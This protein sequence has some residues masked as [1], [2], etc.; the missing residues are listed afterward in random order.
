MLDH[1]VFSQYIDDTQAV[2]PL[3]TAPSVEALYRSIFPGIN[4]AVEYIRVYSAICWMVRQIDLAARKARDP[5]IAALSAAGLEKIQLLLTWYN[6][7]QEVGGLAGADRTWPQDN[8]R[9]TLNFESIPGTQTAKRLAVDPDYEVRDGGAHFLTAPQY[10]PSLV[11][12]MRFLEEIPVLPGT[13]RL[14][15]AG[16]ELAN[17]YEE[18]IEHHERRDWLASVTQVT[19]RRDEMLLLGDMLDLRE[20]SKG[21]MAAFV[22]Q[23]YPDEGDV[24]AGAQWENRWAGLTLALRAMEAEQPASMD[25]GWHGVPLDTV[26]FAMARGISLAGTPLNLD[27]I[28]EVQGWWANLQLRQYLRLAMETLGRCVQYWIHDAVVNEQPRDISDCAQRLGE[29]VEIILREDNR[30]SSVGMLADELLA[31]QGAHGSFFE[32][33]HHVKELRLEDMLGRLQAVCNFR[34][35]AEEEKLAL[36]EVY[37]ALVYCAVEAENLTVNPYVRQEFDNDRIPLTALREVLKQYRS[38]APSAFL[39][40]MVRYYVI[41]LHFSVVQD[42][43]YDGRNRF[44]FILGDNGLERVASKGDVGAVGLMQDRLYHA[45]LLLAQCGLVEHFDDDTW[46]LTKAGRRRLRGTER[47]AQAA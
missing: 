39:A 21:E 36:R 25:A 9:V 44:F 4:N 16:E 31:L 1:P 29:R 15:P 37:I 22:S 45:M 26:R 42:R 3:G 35:N 23:F 17:A 43:T 24:V 30:D 11:R 10:R 40:H 14:T 13:Y 27:E 8:R 34:P 46:G 6:V 28:E 33:S 18:A 7:T 32:A 20:P 19:I 41:L 12:G 38:E 47:A 2:D 5:D